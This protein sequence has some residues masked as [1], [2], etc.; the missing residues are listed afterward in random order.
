MAGFTLHALPLPPIPA[1]QA[2]EGTEWEPRQEE[3]TG[4]PPPGERAVRPVVRPRMRNAPAEVPEGMH[5]LN[6]PQARDRRGDAPVAAGLLARRRS[7]PSGPAPSTSPARQPVGPLSGRESPFVGRAG[8][9]RAAAAPSLTLARSCAHREE[10]SSR[11]GLPRPPRPRGRDANLGPGA[12][13]A[14]LRGGRP[15]SPG[16]GSRPT[17]AAGGTGAAETRAW[18][19]SGGFQGHLPGASGL[20]WARRLPPPPGRRGD[21]GGA[22]NLWTPL[23]RAWRPPRCPR[24]ADTRTDMLLPV[25]APSERRGA[26]EAGPGRCTEKRP[27]SRGRTGPAAG[28]PGLPGDGGQVGFGPLAGA[29]GGQQTGRRPF[30]APPRP[31]QARAGRPGRVGQAQRPDPGRPRFEA[32]NGRPAQAARTAGGVTVTGC[33][34]RMQGNQALLP[35]LGGGCALWGVGGHHPP[36]RGGGGPRAQL[37]ARGG[38]TEAKC[39]CVSVC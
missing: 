4:V 5:R 3:G 35:L 17:R 21:H 39:T 1:A 26:G 29:R 36:G 22:W 6:G 20:P 27:P 32:G 33:L 9:P 16:A 18:P 23:S 25:P 14:P 28:A 31:G 15:D 10:T 24:V 12:A 11:L 30:P 19:R 2:S 38:V 8:A 13:R 37:A 34:G 7:A